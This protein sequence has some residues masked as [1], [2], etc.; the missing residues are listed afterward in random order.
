MLFP[1][2]VGRPSQLTRPLPDFGEVQPQLQ[3]HKHLTLQLVWE[4]YRETQPA[5]YGY[6]RF[7]E[8]YDRWSRNQD[9]V[10]RQEHR[11]GEKMFVCWAGDTLPIHDRRTN[12]IQRLEFKKRM[13]LNVRVVQRQK[14]I[15]RSCYR[16]NPYTTALQ[17]NTSNLLLLKA[18]RSRP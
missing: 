2:T 12:S 13:L 15:D 14:T 1:A 11:A 9:V 3:T 18:R 5:A 8:L 4:E 6:S 10:L 7:C 17:S 16:N